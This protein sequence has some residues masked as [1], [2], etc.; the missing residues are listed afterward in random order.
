MLAGT[1]M[2]PRIDSEIRHRLLAKGRRLDFKDI[3][4][5]RFSHRIRENRRTLLEKIRSSHNTV[6]VQDTLSGYLASELEEFKKHIGQNTCPKIGFVLSED[7]LFDKEIE[8][9][10]GLQEEF[11]EEQLSWIMNEY[12]KEEEQ[13]Q[14]LMIESFAC[15]LCKRGTLQKHSETHP[16]TC[17][18]CHLLL[19]SSVSIDQF[20]F[21]L[22]Q[23]VS[24]HSAQCVSDPQFTL[25][26]ECNASS[27]L[28][29]CSTKFFSLLAL[30]WSF[31]RSLITNPEA[32][33]GGGSRQ[34]RYG[35]KENEKCSKRGVNG[36]VELLKTHLTAQNFQKSVDNV[37]DVKAIV[38]ENLDGPKMLIL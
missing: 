36:D 10:M 24:E 31:S 30:V 5:K 7:D 12:R 14:A 28:M 15:P 11:L 29:I 6:D 13:I 16:I 35:Q 4:R 21:N 33:F 34:A 38:M 1:L 17:T 8:E 27:L 20:G 9:F 26:T 3:L 19:P 18:L 37:V 25:I 32:V 23:N 2:T 22:K